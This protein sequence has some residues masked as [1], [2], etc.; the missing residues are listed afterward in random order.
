MAFREVWKGSVD[1]ELFWRALGGLG[2][3]LR[4]PEGI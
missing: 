1:L 4:D 3:H 2:E